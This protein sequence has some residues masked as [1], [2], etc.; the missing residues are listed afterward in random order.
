MDDL[1][2][3]LKQIIPDAEYHVGPW[4]D[5][6]QNV[7]RRLVAIMGTGGR[8]T[9]EALV[10]YSGFRVMILSPQQGPT[11]AGEKKAI[12]ALGQ[13][14]RDDIKEN[15]RT[16]NLAQIRLIG[17]IMGPGLTENDRLWVQLNFETISF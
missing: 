13:R 7:N 9:R 3:W 1:I 17:G 6:K 16:C 5:S 15:Y 10:D 8:D 2:D 12:Y 14:V 4:S 11:I